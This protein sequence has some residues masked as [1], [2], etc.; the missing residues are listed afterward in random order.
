MESATLTNPGASPRGLQSSPSGPEV[1]SATKGEAS[2]RRLYS[3]VIQSISL[4]TD[5]GVGGAA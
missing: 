5:A 1:A 4:T 3:G 2:I